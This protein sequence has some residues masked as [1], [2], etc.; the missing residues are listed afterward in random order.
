MIDKIYVIN[1]QENISRWE[2][3][4]SQIDDDRLTRF[5]AIDTTSKEKAHAQLMKHGL[6]LVPDNVCHVM[7]FSTGPGHVGCYLSHYAIWNDVINSNLE[8][9]LILED[10]VNL[11]DLKSLIDTI[12]DLPIETELIQLNR[13]SSNF[14]RDEK[15]DGTESYV[16]TNQGCQKLVQHT[17]HYPKECSREIKMPA[18][19]KH[20]ARINRIDRYEPD[21]RDDT[22]RWPVDFFIGMCARCPGNMKLNIEITERVG[23]QG[24]LS[25]TSPEGKDVLTRTINASMHDVAN[26]YKDIDWAWW[27]RRKYRRTSRRRKSRRADL[28]TYIINLDDRSHR[29]DR[30]D[31][32]D[33]GI[34]RIAAVDT[35]KDP[36]I[37]KKFGLSVKPPDKLT[38][39]YFNKCPGAVGCYLSHYLFWKLVIEQDLKSALILEDD[40]LITDVDQLI[41]CKESFKALN[42]Q[43]PTLIQFNKRTSPEK[44]PFWFNGTES[45]AVNKPAA[46]ALVHLTHDFS[47]M[48]GH[49]I[50]YAYDVP[51]TGVT[52]KEL[53][54][55]WESHDEKI[56]YLEKNVIRYAVDKFIGYCSH[57]AIADQRR[58]NIHIEP[59]VGLFDNDVPSDI[60]SDGSSWQTR[61]LGDIK[62]MTR[63]L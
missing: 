20:F 18:I 28:A 54:N 32:R 13:R 8:R 46:E 4:S 47:D 3:I 53:Y 24:L 15:F 36:D 61:S 11:D 62:E 27:K 42:T 25:Q 31:D 16:V 40:A 38:K 26:I 19:M 6:E 23:I 10:D 43:E 60:I 44:L 48:V 14:F 52:S 35:R 7:C 51:T 30:F 55:M 29:W 58:I 2:I 5:D 21:Y 9:V 49:T 39:L 22:I 57:P 12:D 59:V 63:G 33:L 37:A 17:H 34:K 50:E 1:L 45:Y 41:R 56:D